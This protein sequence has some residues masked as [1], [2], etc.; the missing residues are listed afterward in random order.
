MGRRGPINQAACSATRFTFSAAETTCQVS[1][2]ER[3]LVVAGRRALDAR[4]RARPLVAAALVL[5]GPS[6][7]ITSLWPGLVEQTRQRTGGTSGTRRTQELEGAE[8]ERHLER[9]ARALALRL[10]GQALDRRGHAQPLSSEVWSLELPKDWGKDKRYRAPRSP[11][12]PV[13]RLERHG[14]RSLQFNPILRFNPISHLLVPPIPTAWVPRGVRAGDLNNRYNTRRT[15]SDITIEPMTPPM[16]T[17][18]SGRCTSAPVPVLKAIGK[19]AEARHQRRHQHGAQPGD[20][21]PASRLRQARSPVQHSVARRDENHVVEHS[22]A[23]KAMKPMAAEM[24]NG[25]S[26]SQRAKMPRP[27]QRECP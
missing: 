26:R 22:H 24:E 12:P 3:R 10:S 23:R 20:R 27:S 6:T 21:P 14:G 8:D 16:T 4:N 11:L 9:A 5:V 2:G 15:S 19:K 1:R 17:V 13:A 7:A 18:A 25:M